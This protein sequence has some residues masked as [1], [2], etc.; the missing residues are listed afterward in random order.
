MLQYLRR[1]PIP[2]PPQHVVFVAAL[3]GLGRTS[4]LQHLFKELHPIVPT[5]NLVD[6]DE[7][8]PPKF[9]V[10]LSDQL[11][12]PLDTPAFGKIP[13]LARLGR[14]EL[15]DRCLMRGLS[16]IVTEVPTNLERSGSR[17]PE[18]ILAWQEKGI[19]AQL[20]YITMSGSDPISVI[21]ERIRDRAVKDPEGYARMD[22]R[23]LREPGF[24][25]NMCHE[26]DKIV[27][28]LKSSCPRNVTLVSAAPDDRPET[29]ARKLCQAIPLWNTCLSAA[30]RAPRLS[31]YE[32]S[33]R[34]F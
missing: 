34:G 17:F 31:D 24:L 21:R 13:N 27:S 26:Y 8:F 6:S 3:P 5:L 2:A 12:T 10:G 14:F 7:I 25:E 11:Q 33:R 32:I 4:A 20:V 9:R 1:T 22:E 28:R 15:I 16:L 30:Q 18:L 23:K 29:I 19:A